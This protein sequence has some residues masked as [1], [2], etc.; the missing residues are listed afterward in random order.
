MPARWRASCRLRG[1]R[2]GVVRDARSDSY[3]RVH[4]LATVSAGPVFVVRAALSKDRAWA[5]PGGGLLRVR[6]RMLSRVCQV[7]PP[8]QPTWRQRGRGS[9]GVGDCPAEA[10]EFAGDG[11]GD[12]RAALAALVG[13]APP[14]AV[15]ASLRLPGD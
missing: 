12:D 8:P 7:P 10:G 15:Q 5:A 1:R 9:V 3:A 11:D 4:G 2:A 13:E 14:D 6:S